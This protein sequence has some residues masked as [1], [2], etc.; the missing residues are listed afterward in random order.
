MD[1]TSEY[2]IQEDALAAGN[3]LWEMVN[4]LTPEELYCEFAQDP[5]DVS[6]ARGAPLASQ[7]DAS[8]SQDAPFAPPPASQAPLQEAPLQTVW[9]QDEALAMALL[10]LPDLTRVPLCPVDTSRHSAMS[11]WKLAADNKEREDL[12]RAFWRGFNEAATTQGTLPMFT[13][14]A[15]PNKSTEQQMALSAEKS[16]VSTASPAPTVSPAPAISPAP[17]VSPIGNFEPRYVTHSFHLGNNQPKIHTHT[18]RNLSFQP[19]NIFRF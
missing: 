7:D 1:S 4:A 17:T 5:M 12:E 2:G 18:F 16:P 3:A 11:I 8:S 19:G 13:E 10:N 15:S 14:P 9:E 6:P